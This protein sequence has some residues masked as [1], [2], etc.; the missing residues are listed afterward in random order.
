M[1]PTTKVALGLFAAWAVHDL[2][3][4]LTMSRSSKQVFPLL[5]KALPIPEEL[6]REGV[7]QRH[8]NL[9]VSLMAAVMA[10]ASAAGVRSGGR[11]AL[12]RGALLGFGLHGFSHLAMAAAARRY[13]TGAVTAPTVVIPFWLWARR[14]LAR[15]GIADDDRAA[16]AVALALLPLLPAIHV[17][18][19]RLLRPRK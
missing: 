6:R 19:H 1:R 13:V 12:F 8:V 7:P 17:L 9:A 16:T 3:E 5:P 10:A 2:E 14:E 11:S 18:T 4:V 15:Q